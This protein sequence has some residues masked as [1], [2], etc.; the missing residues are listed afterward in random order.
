[1]D[2]K[3]L[4]VIDFS[5]IFN[6]MFLILYLMCLVLFVS[7]WKCGVGE[8]LTRSIAARIKSST[9]PDSI[10]PARVGGEKYL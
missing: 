1:M 3:I 10:F 7:F 8:Q 5:W 4:G 2:S 9:H 6:A